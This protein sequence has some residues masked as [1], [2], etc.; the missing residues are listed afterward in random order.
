MAKPSFAEQIKHPKW[1]R[2]RLEVLSA[3]N[4]TCQKCDADDV[5]LNVHHKQY[6][7][8][9][10]YWE[11]EAHELECL[12]ENCHKEEHDTQD[13]LK[14]LLAEVTTVE[15]FAFIAGFHHH[16]D[17]INAEVREEARNKDPLAYAAGFIG[18]LVYHL[19]I[20]EMDR[21]GEF[22]VSFLPEMAEAR[23]VHEFGGDV[24][25]RPAE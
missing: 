15:A 7:K 10:L 2:K 16:S 24:F 22:A 11:Y 3:A 5:T 23:L 1:Q 19:N 9:R 12:C 21:V 4:W 18:W 25:G 14:S 8:G 20:H 13:G 17:R 6:V